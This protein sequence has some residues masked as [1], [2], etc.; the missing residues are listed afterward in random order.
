MSIIKVK[1]YKGVEVKQVKNAPSAEDAEMRLM[2]AV[3]DKIVEINGI[4]IPQNLVDDEI[5]K[6]VCEQKHKLKYENMASGRCLGLMQNDITA[7]M[8]KIREEAFRLVKIRLVIR[9]ILEAENFE[10]T[11]E[12]L[13]EEARAISVRQQMPVEMVKDFLGED[14]V[15]LKNDLLVRKALDFVLSNAVIK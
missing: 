4:E 14:L 12:E 3:I 13:E 9:G 7:D 8:E 11:K 5:T 15:L 10:I 1:N 6:M 2:D